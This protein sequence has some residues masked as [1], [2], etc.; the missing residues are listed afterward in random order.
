MIYYFFQ[1]RSLTYAQRGERALKRAGISAYIVR[2]PQKIAKSGC[3]YAVKVSQ[4]NLWSAQSLLKEKGISFLKLYRLE[5]TG[6]YQEV[7]L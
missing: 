1:F 2:A 5:S 7:T 4:H 3:S 6:E